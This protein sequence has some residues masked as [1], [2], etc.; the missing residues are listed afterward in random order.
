MH[1]I[2]R[3][4]HYFRKYTP[5]ELTW[6]LENKELIVRGPVEY[7]GIG[8]VFVKY[9]SSYDDADSEDDIQIPG[10]MVPIIKDN[11]FKN[12]LSFMLKMP[13]DDDNNSTLAGIKPHGPQDQEK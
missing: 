12:E 7:S 13:S 4:F 1:S 2:R 6:D 8:S 3:H 11:I 5:R 9:I 10:W